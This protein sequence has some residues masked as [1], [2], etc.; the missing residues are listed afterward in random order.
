MFP[1]LGAPIALALSSATFL[2]TGL[3]LGN[4][5]QSFLDHGWRVP[6]LISIVLLGAG[7]YVRLKIAETP[8]FRQVQGQHRTHLEPQPQERPPGRGDA[9]NGEAGRLAELAAARPSRRSST[10]P[11]RGVTNM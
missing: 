4:T 7:L 10:F 2:V 1:Q 9:A 11:A 5:D 6:F 8:V 3:T